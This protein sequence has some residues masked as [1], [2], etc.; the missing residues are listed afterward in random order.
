MN[1][2]EALDIWDDLEMKFNCLFAIQMIYL[3]CEQ[4][5]GSMELLKQILTLI[6]YITLLQLTSRA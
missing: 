3:L 1:R 2:D 6:N 4:Y 5:Y